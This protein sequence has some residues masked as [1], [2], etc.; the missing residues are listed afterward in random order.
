MDELLHHSVP[1][2]SWLWNEWHSHYIVE[3]QE[4]FIIIITSSF[5][6]FGIVDVR[7]KE[8][9]QFEKNGITEFY[10]INSQNDFEKLKESL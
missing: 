9:Q 4:V 2:V 8:K 10:E 7:N 5:S 6:S 3:N 1:W